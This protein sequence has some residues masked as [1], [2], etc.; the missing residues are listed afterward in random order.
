MT[1]EEIKKIINKHPEGIDGKKI[2]EELGVSY[3][4]S[5]QAERLRQKGEILKVRGDTRLSW[6]YKPI[7]LEAKR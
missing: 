4:I 7:F 5:S 1:Q 6:I 2:Q 3:G